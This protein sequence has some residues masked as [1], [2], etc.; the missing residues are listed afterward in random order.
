MHASSLENM[1]KCHDRYIAGRLAREGRPLRVLDVGGANINGGYADIFALPD[2]VYEGADLEART[3]V[4]IVLD[5]PYML[6]L[7][8]GSVDIVIS[9]QML[10]HCEFFWRSFDEMVRVLRPGGYIFLIAPS[11]GPIHN[12]PVD[13][14]R[15]YPDSYRALAKHAGCHLIDCWLDERG[16]WRDLV[17][18]FAKEPGMPQRALVFMPPGK[19][20]KEYLKKG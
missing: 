15:F 18:V 6:P 9:G 20:K 13:C 12:Y 10:E 5:D 2:F 16:P 11:A 17:G 19:L 7:E 14:Y 8:A 3:G 1:R 4:S